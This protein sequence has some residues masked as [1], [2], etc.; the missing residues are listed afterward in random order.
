M[1]GRC[2]DMS[3]FDRIVE[4]ACGNETGGMG[5][6]NPENCTDFIGNLSHP[7]IVPLP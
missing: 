1:G 7:G 4:D 2:H 6:V 3:I 5:H